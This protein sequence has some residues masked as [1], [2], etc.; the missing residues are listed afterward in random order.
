MEITLRGVNGKFVLER[1]A[2]LMA[3]INNQCS[4]QYTYSYI[5]VQNFGFRSKVTFLYL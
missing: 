3:G 1:E 5:F 2:K 4:Q